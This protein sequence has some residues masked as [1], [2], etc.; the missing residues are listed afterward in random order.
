MSF[1]FFSAVMHFATAI[2]TKCF[3]H[4]S[5][6]LLWTR[7]N[8]SSLFVWKKCLLQTQS[9]HS[10]HLPGLLGNVVAHRHLIETYVAIRA[11]M[12]VEIIYNI[13][14]VAIPALVQV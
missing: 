12:K 1:K 13:L 5:L 14:Q 9:A 8:F 4:S 10:S 6:E 2:C 7:S 3:L 11:C